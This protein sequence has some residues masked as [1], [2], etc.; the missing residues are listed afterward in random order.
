MWSW[1]SVD[2]TFDQTCWTFDGSNNC[3]ILA[4]AGYPVIIYET[5]PVKTV[6][7]IRKKIVQY[8]KAEKTT[9]ISKEAKEAIVSTMIDALSKKEI[10]DKMELFDISREIAIIRYRDTI[11]QLLNDD[12]LAIIL[13]LAS[14]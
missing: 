2:I 8:Q 3:A 9:E 11:K 10:M 1:D 4:G 12:D 13:I 6:K 5:L 14:I 7:N